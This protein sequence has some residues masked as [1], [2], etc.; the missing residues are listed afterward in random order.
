MIIIA[1]PCQIEDKDMC[2]EL[3]DQLQEITQGH[4][5]FFKSSFDKANRSHV[6]APRGVGFDLGANTLHNIRQKGI[7]TLTDVHERWQVGPIL[8]AVDIVQI[9]AF[10]SRQ[11]DL[12]AEVCSETELKRKLTEDKMYPGVNVKKGQWMAPWDVEGILSKTGNDNVW[13]TERGTSFGYNR[14]VVDFTGIQYMRSKYDVPIIL[15]ATHAVQ[16]PG[17]GGTHTIG[18]REYVEGLCRAAVVMGID[19]LFLEVHPNPDEALSDGPNQIT[20]STFTDIIKF[21]ND[22]ERIM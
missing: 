3:A 18:N 17:G 10:L 16:Q 12:I 15:D 20:P 22:Y 19:G 2:Y 5:F 11:T 21:I 1:G 7:R 8:D 9:P 4:D 14:L 6:Q 13:I